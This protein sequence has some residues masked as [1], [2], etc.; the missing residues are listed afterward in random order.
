MPERMKFSKSKIAALN[1]PENGRATC[2]DEIVPKLALRITAA[3]T[4]SFYVVKR[5]GADMVWL[6][7]GTFPD[8]T[9]ERAREEAEKALGDFTADSNPAMIRKAR[10]AEMTAS[11][12]FDKE[13]GPR[14]LFK[15]RSGERRRRVFN[16]H[17][18]PVLGKRKLSDVVRQDVARILSDMDAKGYAGH[19]VNQV[20]N[21]VSG[22]FRHAIEWGF[23][24]TNPV[25]GIRGRKGVE[26]D[27]FIHGDELPRFFHSL[28]AE[29]NE[30]LR[31]YL[32]ISLLTGARRNNVVSMKWSDVRLHE[33]VWCIVRTK[34]DEPQNVALSPEA[35]SILKARVGCDK[36]WVFPGR[37]KRGHITEPKSGWKR[38]L[39]RDELAQILALIKAEGH[40]LPSLNDG[41]SI[42]KQLSLAKLSAEKFEVD[43]SGARLHDLRI[44]DLRRTLGSWQAKSGASL[45]IIGKSLNHK[46][47]AATAIYA[48][49]DLDPVRQSVNMATSAMLAA[50]G[51]KAPA[52][53]VDINKKGV[54]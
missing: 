10:R 12:F 11:E 22:M 35:I 54:A 4:R 49:L 7:L 5:A 40:S 20:K 44:H 30:T 50:G 36:T 19:T 9:V 52:Q 47:Q 48:R 32:L 2:Y 23:S 24:S 28:A 27:R 3:G 31:D 14:H 46:S 13:F 25:T 15:L 43:I 33:G 18:R 29:T 53:V 42:E 21:L 45:V 37:S 26:R 39:D 38:I 17:V 1:P 16:M 51:L 34:N 8:M 41:L 6:K